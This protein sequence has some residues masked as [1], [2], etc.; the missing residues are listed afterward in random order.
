M[1]KSC[2]NMPKIYIFGHA[3][4]RVALLGLYKCAATF[5]AKPV[6]Q[7]RVKRSRDSGSHPIWL[8]LKMTGRTAASTPKFLADML[9]WVRTNDSWAMLMSAIVGE[10]RRIAEMT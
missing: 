8:K 9:D 7:K 1:T 5:Q 3:Q 6:V 10:Y 4:M 2:L